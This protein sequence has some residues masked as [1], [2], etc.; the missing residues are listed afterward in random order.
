MPLNDNTAPR[1]DDPPTWPGEDGLRR[2]LVESQEDGDPATVSH[3]SFGAH[4][5]THIDAP[6]HFLAGGAGVES[7][8]LEAVLGPACVADLTGVTGTIGAADLEAAGIPASTE[9]LLARTRNSGWSRADTAFREDYVAYDESAARWCLDRGVRLVGID[10]LSIEPFDAPQRGYPVH[11]L[12]LEAGVA[13]LE[14]VDLADVPPG[15]YELAALPLHIPG[16]D[17]APVR[18][19]L[20]A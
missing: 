4:T 12:L 7:V 19:I 14:G 11:T 2:R 15:V 17:G 18:A 8:P 5:G 10:Y 1:R 13:V 3:L 20:R 6:V 16:S 9:R